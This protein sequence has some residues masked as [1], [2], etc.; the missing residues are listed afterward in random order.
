MFSFTIQDNC[1][2][3]RLR[4]IAV[5]PTRLYA[6]GDCAIVNSPAIAVVGS[7]AMT[8][9]GERACSL[10]VRGLV[11]RGATIIS[12]LATGIDAVAHRTALDCGGKTIAVLGSGLDDAVLF[13]AEHRGLAAR[14]IKHGG[15][16]LSEYPAGEVAKRY[17]FPVRNRIIAGLSLG[18]V[19]IEAQ[20]KSGALLTAA[21]ALEAN[22]EV[23]AV[24]GSIFSSRSQ[25]THRLVQQGAQLV[26]SAADICQT[27]E[28]YFP[29]PLPPVV[30]TAPGQI[31]VV[32]Q[33]I[34]S[35]LQSGPSHSEQLLQML[36]M[37]APELAHNLTELEIQGIVRRNQDNSYEISDC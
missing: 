4:E 3:A 22:R 18:V 8:P 9:Y 23:F 11:Q 24:P 2:P 35:Q 6:R 26:T 30:V 19:V 1:Y 5:P 21:R 7:R 20:Q 27:L 14:I 15:V 31:T 17:Y 29:A 10:I 16:L 34:V 37:A 12:G 36:S 32:Q 13:P 28:Q 33:R 25:G